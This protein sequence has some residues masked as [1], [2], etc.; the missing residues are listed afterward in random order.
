[1]AEVQRWAAALASDSLCPLLTASARLQEEQHHRGCG[2]EH[3][4]LG[5]VADLWGTGKL[6]RVSEAEPAL[7]SL[8]H[9]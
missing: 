7:G 1:M 6:V 9:P 4:Q 5:P 3:D 8:N 2:R